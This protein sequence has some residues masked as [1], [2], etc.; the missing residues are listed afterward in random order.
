MAGATWSLLSSSAIALVASL[1]PL[2]A[3]VH[4]QDS[5]PD[6]AAT[7]READLDKALPT[8]KPWSLSFEP[9]LWRPGIDGGIQ[10]PG[11]TGAPDFQQFGVDDA[12]PT[13]MGFLRFR[14]NRFIV[15]ASGFDFS[16]NRGAAADS[17]L[18]V[19]GINFAPGQSTNIDINYASAQIVAGR[20]LIEY[21]LPDTTA[22]EPVSFNIDVFG[23]VRGYSF[24]TT[25]ATGASSAS[26]SGF[27]IEPII[28]VRGSIDIFDDVTIHLSMDGGAQPFGDHTSNS[29]D[30]TFGAQWRPTPHV[31]V[32]LGWRQ[33]VVNLQNGSGA[34]QLDFSDGTLAGLYGSLV[35]RF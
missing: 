29:F 3:P 33:L 4:A 18:S 25:I 22:D 21:I 24:K 6:A 8:S 20:R 5:Q 14:K 9:S 19:G 17:A 16:M 28:G 26:E 12:H 30:I 2:V 27:W 1:I 7:T 13:A 32:Q 23:G 10:L 11:G 31:G 34:S 15:E 35:L